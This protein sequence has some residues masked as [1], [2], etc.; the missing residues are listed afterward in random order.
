MAISNMKMSI[1]V[2]CGWVSQLAYEDDPEIKEAA[3]DRGFQF[4]SRADH[5]NHAAIVMTHEDRVFVAFRGTRFCVL[6][7]WAA[8]VNI[9][10]IKRPWGR[11]HRGFVKA[12]ESLWPQIS[13]TI[14]EA[15]KAGKSIYFTGHSL[16]GAMAVIS[17]L[18]TAHEMGC[19]VAGIVTFGQPPLSSCAMLKSLKSPSILHYSRFVNSVDIVSMGPF[20]PYWHGGTHFFFDADNQMHQQLPWRRYVGKYFSAASKFGGRFTFLSQVRKHFMTDYVK[21]LSLHFPPAN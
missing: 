12:T 2:V 11:A 6:R 18:K 5:V 4:D 19:Q 16:G 9:L 17:A 13:N 14:S 20:V 21:L 10:P 7:D 1:P 15:S 3:L 8:N